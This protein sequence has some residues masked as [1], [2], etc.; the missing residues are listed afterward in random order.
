ME[1]I[2]DD[3]DNFPVVRTMSERAGIRAMLT[4]AEL[5]TSTGGGKGILLGGISWVPSAKVVILGAGIV[6]ENA[7]RVALGLGAE[8]RIFDNN[9]YKLKRLQNQ[10]GRQLYTS[11]IDPYYLNEELL[12][13]DVAIGA[14]HSKSGRAP[15]IV[16][17]EMVSR[18]RPGAVIVD[19]S[20]DQG[21][22]FETSQV[23][24]LD[25]PTFFRHGIVH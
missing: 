16:S 17:E 6:A 15:V 18:M 1:Y 2:K 4:A 10:V 9:I 21:G 14:I 23:T 13:A 24:S 3:L 20:I 5:L 22:C 8:V 19:V 25:K 12:T 7:T 11:S